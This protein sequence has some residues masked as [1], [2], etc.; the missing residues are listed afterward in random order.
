MIDVPE[1]LSSAAIENEN[2]VTMLNQFGIKDTQTND[3]LATILKNGHDSIETKQKP[4]IKSKDE[5]L[6]DYFRILN[7]QLDEE[8]MMSFME[9]FLTT[10][11]S[12]NS[13]SQKLG[14]PKDT[15][16]Q[17]ISYFKRS[18]RINKI[19]FQEQK[20]RDRKYNQYVIRQQIEN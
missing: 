9:L 1:G 10:K 2:Y 8:K 16:Y 20:K 6:A 13:I 19:G 18:R 17:I 11:W 3:I 4:N 14:I 12:L 15:C 7:P 5:H